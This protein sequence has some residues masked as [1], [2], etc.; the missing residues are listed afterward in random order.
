MIRQPE[1]ARRKADA[2]ALVDRQ[3]ALKRFS[4]WEARNPRNP[5][6]QAALN[7]VGFLYDLLPADKRSRPVDTSGV[8]AMHRALSV[9]TAGV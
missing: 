5:T 4:A 2:R 9:L 1:R 3:R 7:A 8:Q 6:P